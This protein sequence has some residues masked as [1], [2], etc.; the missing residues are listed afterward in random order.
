MNP[1]GA[2]GMSQDPC[3]GREPFPGR[4]PLRPIGHGLCEVKGF[5]KVREKARRETFFPHDGI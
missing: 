1:S 3:G 5:K 4:S 2:D